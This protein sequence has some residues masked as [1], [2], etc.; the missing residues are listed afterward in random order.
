[1]WRT[2]SGW[3]TEWKVGIGI[4]VFIVGVFILAAIADALE[5]EESKAARAYANAQKTAVAQVEAE[6][7]ALARRAQ[8]EQEEFEKAEELATGLHCL[9]AWDGHH[10]GFKNLVK[11]QLNDPD[12]LKAR[13]TRI[14]RVGM[15]I[16]VM[17]GLD[18]QYVITMNFTAQNSFGGTVRHDAYGYVSSDGCEALLLAN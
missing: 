8:K 3:R 15:D 17:P 1:M 6:S 9:S 12:S 4:V 13:E 7:T 18:G 14:G 10:N 2:I 5:S 16:G 11:P